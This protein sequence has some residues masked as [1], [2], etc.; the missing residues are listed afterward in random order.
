MWMR[1]KPES[2]RLP[3]RRLSSTPALTFEALEAES[4]TSHHLWLLP[5][6]ATKGPALVAGST[7]SNP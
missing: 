2:R 7:R 3:G 5:P 4:R 6:V 1:Q